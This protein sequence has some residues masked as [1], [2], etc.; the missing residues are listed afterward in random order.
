MTC[1][2]PKPWNVATCAEVITEGEGELLTKRPGRAYHEF[3]C[4]TCGE[5][6]E[7][8]FMAE[9]KWAFGDAVAYGAGRAI[10]NPSKQPSA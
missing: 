3:T 7:T 8:K 2:H 6:V 9:T 5:V 4:Q 1:L 10:A